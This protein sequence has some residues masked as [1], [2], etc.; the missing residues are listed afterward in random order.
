MSIQPL[1]PP[2]RETSTEAAPRVIARAES[3]TSSNRSMWLVIGFITAIAFA[4]MATRASGQDYDSIAMHPQLQSEAAAKRIQSLSKTYLL[5]GNGS[6]NSVIG[7]YQHYVPAKMTE[8]EGFKNITEL[9]KET[10][11]YLSRVQRSNRPQ[12]AKD[13]LQSVYIGMKKVVEGNHHPSARI[14]AILVLSRLDISPADNSARRPPV[15]LSNVLPILMKAYGDENNVDGVRAAALQGIH[16][17]VLY[18]FN[19]IPADSRTTIQTEM[20]TLLE[21][22]APASRDPAAHAYLQRFAVDILDMLRPPQD[23]T[24]G[25][26]LVS[27]STNPDKH[28]LI[29]LYSASKLGPMGTAMKDK[30]AEPDAL[31]NS[32]AIRAYEALRDESLRLQALT[33]PKP[34]QKQP[35]KAEDYLKKQETTTAPAVNRSMDMDAMMEGDMGM[36]AAM[37]GDM[38]MQMGGDDMMEMMAGGMGMGMGMAA[39]R[40]QPPQVVASRRKINHVLQQL[41]LGVTGVPQPGIPTKNIGGVLASVGENKEAVEAWLTK[42]EEVMTALNDEMLDD[43]K[44][45]ETELA[46]QLEVMRAYLGIEAEA[47]PGMPA[48]MAAAHAG[49]DDADAAPGIPDAAVDA[50]G[51]ADELAPV[52]IDELAP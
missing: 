4:M 43:E 34:A 36:E 8:P 5:S 50:D 18:S 7:Y 46:N 16:R 21:A 30:I 1:S 24:L 12:V 44:K 42:M 25:D 39:A 33:R 23:T 22:E 19:R 17:H 20:T 32:W 29:A 41:H 47:I 3:A 51:A 38:E 6:K 26:K 2:N 52:S 45:Y 35:K 37:M 10:L 13:L 48:A 9:S 27:I 14:N 11:A 40:P 28:N 15:P 49:H 31:L